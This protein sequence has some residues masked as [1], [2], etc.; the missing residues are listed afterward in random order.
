[1]QLSIQPV[2]QNM[3]LDQEKHEHATTGVLDAEKPA[4]N[5]GRTRVC[6][7]H[8]ASGGF[9]KT[10]LTGM[11]SPHKPQPYKNTCI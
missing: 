8:P 7:Q 5:F 3:P 4:P 2:I 9:A 1:M 6:V 10:T 11:Q